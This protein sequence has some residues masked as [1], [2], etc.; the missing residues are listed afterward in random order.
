M[1]MRELGVLDRKEPQVMAILNATSDSFSDDGVLVEV[2]PAAAAGAV[3]RRAQLEG[4]SIVDIGGASTRPG[5]SIVS[6]TEE[7]RRVRLVFDAALDACDLPLS[8]DTFHGDVAR[9]ALGAGASIVNSV[10]GLRTDGGWNRRLADACVE[11]GAWLVLTHCGMRRTGFGEIGPHDVDVGQSDIVEVVLRDLDEQAAA[12]S[13][14]GIRTDRL[15]LDP[16]V[17]FG[18]GPRQCE[19]ILRAYPRF[20][21]LGLPVILAVSRKSVLG[22]LLGDAANPD[23]DAATIAVSALASDLG[24][25]LV[26]VHDVGRNAQ[27]IRVSRA[28]ARRATN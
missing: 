26:R 1:A 24:A 9:H 4:A 8:I 17:G 21:G 16:G 10:H 25:A 14:F 20:A 7:W 5:A 6:S 27:A 15:I 23:R 11:Y 13:R 19:D 12:A 22:H 28:L 2:D 3:A 18:K